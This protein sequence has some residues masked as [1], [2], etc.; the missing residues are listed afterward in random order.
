MLI[1]GYPFLSSGFAWNTSGNVPE[2]HFSVLSY[3]VKG[4]HGSRKGDD[5]Q[6]LKYIRSI[7]T[8]INCIQEFSNRLNIAQRIQ[9]EDRFNL[10]Y[11]QSTSRLAIYTRFRVLKSG[12]LIPDQ[13]YNNIMFADL[14]VSDK[15]TL[16]VYNVHLQSM[17]ITHTN[18]DYYQDFAAEYDDAKT[19]FLQGAAVRSSQ[20]AVMLEHIESCPY[21]VLVVGDFNDTPFSYNYHKVR[22]RLDNSFEKAGW[23]FGFTYNGDLPFLRIDNQFFSEGLKLFDFQTID[24]TGYSDH[25][26]ILGIYSIS[27]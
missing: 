12:V 14:L 20:V 17:G 11:D 9:K 3:N 10:V 6:M 23:G 13:T 16:R 4:F 7:S 25:Y 22:R 24:S 26:P 5:K 1:L 18:P 21:P 19:K 2:D 15:D 8:D 27:E